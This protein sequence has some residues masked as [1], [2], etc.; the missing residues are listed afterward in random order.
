MDELRLFS[1]VLGYLVTLLLIRWV[2]LTQR[3]HPAATVAWILAIILL[4]YLGGLLYL[5]FGINRVERRAARIEAASRVIHPHLPPLGQYQA[6]C[7]LV[8]NDLQSRLLRLASADG[9]TAPTSGNQIDVL[10]DTNL[11]L[12]RIEVA[13]M[14]AKE[15]LHLEYYIWRPDKTGRRVRDFL[16]EKA[17][18]GVKVRFLYD[19]VGS[20]F[21]NRRFF[22]PMLDAGIAVAPFIPGRSLRAKWSINLRSHRKIVIVDG[23]VGF[24]GGMNIGDEYLGRNKTLGYW[25][26]THLEMRGPTVLQLQRVFAEDWYCATGEDLTDPQRFPTPSMAGDVVAQV[27]SSGPIGHARTFHELIFTAINEARERITL[28][29]SYFVPTEPL[30][31]ALETAARRGVRVRLLLA[32]RS[33][34]YWTIL[35]GR[36]YYEALLHAGVEIHEYRRG[37]QHAKTLTIDGQW[38]LVGSAN[39]DARSLL[40]NFEVGVAIYDPRIAAELEQHYA[41]DIVHAREIRLSQW[42]RRPARSVF[43][44]NACRLFAPL[45]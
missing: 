40:L 2:V 45:L 28:A 7:G 18:A 29:T 4:P 12:R 24:T 15:S 38:S 26:D 36:S 10:A 6:D 37:I 42:E 1:L 11:T 31:M 34:H 32:G 39:F 43:A 5:F 22:R 27:I 17:R 30:M 35:A 9:E 14:E 13:I 41:T 21:L 16:V 33:A 19:G 8:L 3:R 25:R 20:L 23:R 44:E